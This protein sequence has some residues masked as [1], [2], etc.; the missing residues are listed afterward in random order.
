MYGL[1]FTEMS[2][3]NTFFPPYTSNTNQ[4][5]LEFSLLKLSTHTCWFGKPCKWISRCY[6]CGT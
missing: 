1:Q 5:F 2:Q 4:A 3:V 6:C